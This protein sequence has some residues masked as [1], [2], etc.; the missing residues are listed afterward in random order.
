MLLS[1]YVMAVMDNP[2]HAT[3]AMIQV[4]PNLI[5]RLREIRDRSEREILEHGMMIHW[6]PKSRR[7]LTSPTVE[8]QRTGVS[9]DQHVA[10]FGAADYIGTIHTH[11]YLL[12]LGADAEIGFSFA[13]FVF[14]GEMFPRVMPLGVNFVISNTRLFLAVFREAT[15][16]VIDNTTFRD[17]NT[18]EID[19]D[20]Y[21]ESKGVGH[22]INEITG[23]V[24]QLQHEG[25][26]LESATVER[27]FY[28]SVPGY[29]K[30]RVTFNRAMIRRAAQNMRFEAYEG[31]LAGTL[32][33]QSS[34]VYAK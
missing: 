27:R 2:Q 30:K 7:F 23:Q 15:Q 33:L 21:L 26:L 19:A 31:H 10:S 4:D 22:R 3:K 6:L 29:V 9:W 1:D 32:H 18:D 25:R 8:G 20:N 11:P 24:T 17:L 13:D 34:R 16:K 12:K 28:R 5:A 14:Y